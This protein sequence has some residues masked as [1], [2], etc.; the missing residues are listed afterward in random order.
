MSK[1]AFDLIICILAAPLW[2]PVLALSSL[3]ILV[4]NGW[5][6]LYCSHRRV[7]RSRSIRVIKFR[8]M[9]RNAEK[10]VNRQTVPLNGERFL[11][12]P[13]SSPAYTRMGRLLEICSL[14]ELP[15][16]LHVLTGEMSLVGNRPLPEDVIAALREEFPYAEDRFLT[17]CGLAG[18][19]Q[20]A[21]R[22]RLSDEKR[23]RIE[24]GYCRL[25]LEAYSPRLDLVILLYTVL[26]CLRL[27][28]KLSTEAV[29]AL[30]ERYAGERED[31]RAAASGASPSIPRPGIVSC[32]DVP[33]RA[34]ARSRTRQGPDRLGIRI[35]GED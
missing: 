6:V 18:P 10:I 9:V 20:L 25:C 24:I 30:M 22:D 32:P 31:L 21:G 26:I 33:P 27:K 12:I 3:A 11:N 17:Q 13:R 14:T 4:T 35:P 1:R 29:V 2:I 5:P 34:P 16:L 28:R 23:L 19:T 8:A 7:Y 15:Q